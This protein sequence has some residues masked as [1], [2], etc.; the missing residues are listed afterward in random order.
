MSVYK[1]W[2]HGRSIQSLIQE[3]GVKTVY[4]CLKREKINIRRYNDHLQI[5]NETTSRWG[6]IC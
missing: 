2:K 1:Q 6:K 5:Y 4:N 3:F